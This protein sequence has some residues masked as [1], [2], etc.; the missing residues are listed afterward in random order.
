MKKTYLIIILFCSII[1]FSMIPKNSFSQ[2]LV[3]EWRMQGKEDKYIIFFEDGTG[4]FNFDSFWEETSYF[5]YK[6]IRDEDKEKLLIEKI[7]ENDNSE[8][9]TYD[10]V[11]QEYKLTLVSKRSNILRFKRY[12]IIPE[13]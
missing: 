8:I 11:L 4:E 12:Y 7:N 6:I 1:Q 10:F 13:N 9:N 5:K 3:G 2:G